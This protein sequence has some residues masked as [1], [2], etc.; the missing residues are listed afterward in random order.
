MLTQVGS[1]KLIQEIGSGSLSTVYK[2]QFGKSPTS[3]AL[4]VV[5]LRYKSEADV[6]TA[7]QEVRILHAM[8][9]P[10]IVPL[11]EAFVDEEQKQLV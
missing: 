10:C 7:V 2:G 8:D 4:K 6:C 5:D 1:Y 11:H 9:H 3:F